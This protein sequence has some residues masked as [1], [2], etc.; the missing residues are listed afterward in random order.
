MNLINQSELLGLGN[1]PANAPEKKEVKAA[2]RAKTGTLSGKGATAKAMYERMLPLLPPDIQNAVKKGQLQLVDEILYS[3]KQ[4]QKL[5]DRELMES[6]D[7]KMIG[8]TNVDK[9]K[10]E[11]NKW[12]LLYAI[13][14]LSGV[15]ANPTQTVFDVCSTDILNGEFELEVGNTVIVPNV[16][17]A[18][19]DTKGRTDMAKGLW[20][21]FDPQFITPNT[22]I[23]PR[24]KLATEAKEN[25]N[26]Y[27]AMHVVSVAKN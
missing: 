12:T 25:T 21:E 3:N 4:L 20:K 23:K 7:N 5:R 13:Q 2:M 19:F 11:A 27:F 16:S 17:C 18:V 15:N 1:L 22:E 6:G 9:Q 14:L 10:I 8:M 24:L 26:V